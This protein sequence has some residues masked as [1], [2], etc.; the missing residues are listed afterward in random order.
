MSIIVD[1]C[2]FSII[3]IN[4]VIIISSQNYVIY[5]LDGCESLLSEHHKECG[6]SKVLYFITFHS[7]L[8]RPDGLLSTPVWIMT[9]LRAEI[10]GSVLLLKFHR[11]VTQRPL[12]LCF[13]CRADSF[14][15]I[16][17]FV[18]SCWFRVN[19]THFYVRMLSSFAKETQFLGEILPY[20]A[21]SLH[22]KHSYMRF[23]PPLGP[24]CRN[25]LHQAID[26]QTVKI[27]V[28]VLIHTL[29][30][31]ALEISRDL[32]DLFLW[33]SWKNFCPV[34]WGLFFVQSLF[35]CFFH[36]SF[37]WL[38]YWLFISLTPISTTDEFLSRVI[39][40]SVYSWFFHDSLSVF[41]WKYW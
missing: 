26:I 16:W 15:S 22:L 19:E 18:I 7:L 14:I 39:C 33:G 28:F 8:V 20:D 12:P 9:D 37:W 13:L 4:I 41:F 38:C 23:L 5:R 36:V 17:D 27:L 29:A 31:P 24:L 34:R 6:K 40:Q 3:D 2:Y 21:D 30:E 1:Y 25:L 32:H 11:C 35:S 10:I